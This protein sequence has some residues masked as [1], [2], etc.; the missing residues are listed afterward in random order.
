MQFKIKIMSLMLTMSLLLGGTPIEFG[1]S[2]TGGYDNNAMRF[3]MDEI[4][5]AA[6]EIEMMGGA[7]T[8]DS[9]V[10]KWGVSALKEMII[11]QK[12]VIK[13]KGFL[14]SS[15]YINTPEKKYWSGGTDLTYKWGPYRNIKYSLR[16]LDR[17][18]L[19]HYVNRDIAVGDLA[20]CVF[21]DRS[22]AL[23]ITQRLSKVSWLNL[24]AGYLQRY[25]SRPFTEFDLDIVYLKAKI[26][27]KLKNIGSVAVQINQ[28]VANNISYSSQIRPSS[29]D[30]SYDTMELFFPLKMNKNLPIVS[31]IGVSLRAE[32]REYDAED[33]SD[34]LH[35]G[36]SHVDSKYDMWVKKKLTDEISLTLSSR[37]RTRVT[38][39]EYEWVDDLKSFKQFQFWFNIEWDMI[40]DKY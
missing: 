1:V 27:Y 31:E 6:Q 30:R 33:L 8:F 2:L 9:F 26:N 28:G 24:G 37:F 38:E 21:T 18:Y 20:S 3:S 32:F 22:H 16:H 29:F 40:Y 4:N 11:G 17:F 14:A 34:P 25:Y 39:S 23:T 12:K 36:R 7:K 15:D 35:S 19:R 10:T 5:E 13:L